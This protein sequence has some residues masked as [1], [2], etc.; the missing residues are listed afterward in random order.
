MHP[1]THLKSIDPKQTRYVLQTHHTK[2]L[3]AAYHHLTLQAPISAYLNAACYLQPGATYMLISPEGLSNQVRKVQL[4]VCVRVRVC[5]CVG[6]RCV[7]DSGPTCP[8]PRG[9]LC[10]YPGACQAN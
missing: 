6:I 3:S 7:S 9:P 8:G 2:T 4:D 10:E 1:C 5:V